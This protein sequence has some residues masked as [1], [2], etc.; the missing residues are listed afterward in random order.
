MCL[1]PLTDSLG[2][3]EM[4]LDAALGGGSLAHEVRVAKLALAPLGVQPHRLVEP[5]LAEPGVIEV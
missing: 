5:A 2:V 4:S 1:R 3:I